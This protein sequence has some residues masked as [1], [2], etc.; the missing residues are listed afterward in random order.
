VSGTIAGPECSLTR[1]AETQ[2]D[3]AAIVMGATGATVTY[4]EL[5]ARSNQCARLF[6]SRGLEPGHHVAICCE[7]DARFLDVV[8]AA[9]RSGLYYTPISTLLTADELAYVVQDCGARALVVSATLGPL[10]TAIVD[11]TPGVTAR[12]SIGGTLPGHEALEPL[13]DAFPGTARE[14]EPAGSEMFYSS[15]TTGRPKGVRKS[16]TLAPVWEPP[17]WFVS[18]LQNYGFTRDTVWLSTGPLYHAGPLYGCMAAHRVGATVVVMERFEPEPALRLIERHRV[19]HAQWVPTMFS[20]MLKLPDDVRARYDLSSQQ[21]AIHGGAPCP[22]AV[23]RAMIDWWGPIVNEFYSGTEGSGFTFIDSQDWLAHPGSVGRATLG[24]VHVVGEDGQELPAGVDGVVYFGGGPP[25]EYHNDPDKTAT[26]HHPAGWATLGDV[27]HVDD[28]GYLYLT[29]RVAFTIISGGVNIYPR[30]AE[31]V[32]LLHPSVAD[33]GVIGV[34]D[35]DLGEQVKAVVQLADGVAPSPVLADELV[36]YCRER[37]A[38][39]KCPRSVDFVDVL[40]RLPTG[41]LQKSEIRR[42]YW[43]RR[44]SRLV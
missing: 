36:A 44:S 37:L 26:A 43:S 22:I 21:F 8:W 32:L 2:P 3:A 6:A 14:H 17:P 13:L 27:G 41:K 42:P 24:H 9:Q 10:A 29:D 12:F 38:H 34:P 15:G 16:L 39:F 40:P 33:V 19:T 31:D 25:F 11:A 23:K 35:D 28:D 20:R 18:Y 5:E 4:A 7:N 30:E 1:H